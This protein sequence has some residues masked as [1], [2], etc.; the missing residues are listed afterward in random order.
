MEW[1][2]SEV[3]TVKGLVFEFMGCF[4][5]L[6]EKYIA[7]LDNNNAFIQSTLNISHKLSTE[8]NTKISLG[9]VIA[10]VLFIIKQSLFILENL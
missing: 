6:K 4:I 2:L 10:N 5:D 3:E 7:L 8:D 1:C 9:Y